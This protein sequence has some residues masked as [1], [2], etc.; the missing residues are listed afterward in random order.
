[1]APGRSVLLIYWE[2]LKLLTRMIWRVLWL[3]VHRCNRH[4][5]FTT[6]AGRAVALVL[7]RK[8]LKYE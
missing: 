2:M 5:L 1:M 6:E 3:V 4:Q 8:G 7:E